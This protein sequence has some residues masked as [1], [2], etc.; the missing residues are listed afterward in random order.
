LP[1][2]LLLVFGDLFLV[3]GLRPNCSTWDRFLIV[4]CLL[5]L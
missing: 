3:L 4:G 5:E 1:C 2:N